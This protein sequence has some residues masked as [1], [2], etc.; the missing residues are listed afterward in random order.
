MQAHQPQG[1]DAKASTLEA[2]NHPD[3]AQ[4]IYDLFMKYVGFA[5]VDEQMLIELQDRT[6]ALGRARGRADGTSDTQ[7][8]QAGQLPE[9]FLLVTADQVER[10]SAT[11]WECPPQSRVVLLSTLRRLTKKNA[12][13]APQ[14]AKGA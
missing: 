8:G 3:D 10:H 1:G 12:A 5:H 2:G 4:A 14:P 9:G 6:Y 13:P 11:A 7:G